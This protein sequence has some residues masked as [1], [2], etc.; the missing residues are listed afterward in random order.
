M[1]TMMMMNMMM[2][3]IMMM[4]VMIRM[5]MITRSWWTHMI[6]VRVVSMTM[7]HE[8]PRYGTGRGADTSGLNLAAVGIK[9]NPRSGKIATDDEDAVAGA[10]GAQG[11]CLA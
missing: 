4:V 1:M 6:I 10:E 11:S 9:P 8:T 2:K 5:L 3:T 7:T